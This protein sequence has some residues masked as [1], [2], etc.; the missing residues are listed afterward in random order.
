MADPTDPS[1]SR[2]QLRRAALQYHEHPTPGKLAV[3][4]TK[5]LVNQRDLALAYSPGVAAPCEE[6][7]A[8]PAAA[9][10][11]TAQA[12]HGGAVGDHRHQIG[13]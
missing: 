11:Y 5:Q 2:E 6:I 7:V 8:D 12:K 3:S 9:Y 10:R 13:A 1:A 4:A